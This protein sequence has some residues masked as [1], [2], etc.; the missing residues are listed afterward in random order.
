MRWRSISAFVFSVCVSWSAFCSAADADRFPTTYDDAIS[1]AV[2]SWWPPGVGWLWWKA[3]LY[4]ESRLDPS[5]VSP[6]GARGLAQF[7]PATWAEVSRQLGLGVVSPHLARPA[8]E[9]G[10]FYMARL[11]RG[12]SS[13]RPA[14]DR[15]HLARASYNAGFGSLLEAQRRCGGPVGFEAIMACLP[16]VTGPRNS[17]ETTTYVARIVRWHA[18]LVAACGRC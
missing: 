12:W 13:P 14:L 15:W 18:E 10:A 17:H 6:A 3:Q 9:A 5:A 16:A 11:V 2:A 8:I 1:S 7:M 4:Q